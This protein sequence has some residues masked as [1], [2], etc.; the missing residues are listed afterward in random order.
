M[1]HRHD[2]DLARRLYARPNSMIKHLPDLGESLR[3]AAIEIS[4]DC[5]IPRID[6]MLV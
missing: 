6:E 1:N 2:F 3:T 5:T 4:H